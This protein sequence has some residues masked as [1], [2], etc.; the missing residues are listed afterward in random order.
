MELTTGPRSAG[1][2][3]KNYLTPLEAYFC[4]DVFKAA[5]GLRLDQALEIVNY[6][7]GHYEEHVADQ[8]TGQSYYECYDRATGKPSTQWEEID[9]RVRTDLRRF[10]LSL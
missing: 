7:L 4:A 8:P 5:A 9:A 6:C 1:G 10:G 2:A 3:L